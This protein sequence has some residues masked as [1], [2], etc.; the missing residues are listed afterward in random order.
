MS[1]TDLEVLTQ[2]ELGGLKV[3]P[4]SDIP[5]HVNMLI[6]GDP[7]V[8]K[9]VLAGSASV[10]ERMAPVLVIDIE[11]GTL[12]LKGTYPHVDIVRVETWKDMQQ[13]YDALYDGKHGYN[14]VVLDSLTEIQKFSMYLI[15][16]DLIKSDPSRDPDIPGMREWGK[17]IEQIRR[18][19]RAFRDLPINTVVTALAKQDRDVRTGMTK[20]TPS[21][22]GKLANEVAGFL[23][24]VMYMYTK[25]VNKDGE[26]EFM[27]L[28]LT[29]PT[30]T[31]VAKDRTGRLPQVVEQPT[32]QGL[33]DCIFETDTGAT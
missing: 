7:G 6:Y 2:T 33:V 29:Q 32:M 13:V 15:M 25:I 19:I 27:R 9:T 14:T 12:S 1:L 20:T 16:G 31:Q 17:N 21:L 10:V 5:P 8:G 24:I 26:T 11:G 22:S 18:L 4:V 3:Q 30:D 23:D 28:L